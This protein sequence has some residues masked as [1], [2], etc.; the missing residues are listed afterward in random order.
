[1]TTYTGKTPVLDDEAMRALGF[2]DRV[3]TRWYY[4]QR[5]DQRGDTTLNITIEKDSGLYEELVMNERFG[6]P[7]PYGQM[8]PE[9]RD[10]YRDTI[11]FQLSIL[12]K[13]GLTI[14]VDHKEYGCE[15]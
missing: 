1:M 9:W 11:D 12:N 4:C 15:K 5:I 6:Q 3:E 14:K 10:L 13:A 7:E 2:T 8:K